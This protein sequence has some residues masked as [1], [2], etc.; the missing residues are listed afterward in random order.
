METP[1][2]PWVL[3][4]TDDPIDDPAKLF[5]RLADTDVDCTEIDDGWLVR[6]DDNGGHDDDPDHSAREKHRRRQA[7]Y[8]ARKRDAGDGKRDAPRDAGDGGDALKN[9]PSPGGVTPGPLRGLGGDDTAWGDAA[10]TPLWGVTRDARDAD[11]V[12]PRDARDGDDETDEPTPIA[13][14]LREVTGHE[15][16]AGDRVPLTDEQCE[17]GKVGI[18]HV[19]ATLAD[20]KPR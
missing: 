12:T 17:L 10:V 5:G 20:R 3:I 9:L 19:R 11:G 2:M 13:R 6:A 7:R 18:A 15:D 14:A 16:W 1:V 8:R 4:V